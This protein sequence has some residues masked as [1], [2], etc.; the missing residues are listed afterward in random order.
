MGCFSGLQF[1]WPGLGS[2]V[3]SS[4]L[5]FHRPAYIGDTVTATCRYEGFDGPK[6]SS[7]AA[8][9]VTDRFLNRYGA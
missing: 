6:Q 8:V 3:S 5:T 1:G 2:F 7:F 9:I 4:D